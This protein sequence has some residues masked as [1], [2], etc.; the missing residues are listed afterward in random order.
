MEYRTS[1]DLRNESRFP[2]PADSRAYSK[3][4]IRESNGEEDG[5]TPPNANSSRLPRPTYAVAATQTATPIR[6][7]RVPK[8]VEEA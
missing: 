7:V 4:P 1:T 2:A 8:R 3:P 6:R 5:M